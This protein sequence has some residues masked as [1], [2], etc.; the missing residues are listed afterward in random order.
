MPT[1]LVTMPTVLLHRNESDKVTLF[2]YYNH[3]LTDNTMF[4]KL[5]SSKNIQI[6]CG[7]QNEQKEG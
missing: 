7:G 2:N 5:K 1:V 6:Y 4:E 3:Y